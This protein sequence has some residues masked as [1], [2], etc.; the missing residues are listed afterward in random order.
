MNSFVGSSAGEN[1]QYWPVKNESGEEI[2]A[3][4]CMRITGTFIPFTTNDGSLVQPGVANYGFTVAKP[5]E[6]GAQF[7]HM[8]NGPMTIPIGQIGQGVFGKVMQGLVHASFSVGARCGPIN[9]SWTLQGGSGGFRVVESP[10]LRASGGTYAGIVQTVIQ[11]PLLFAYGTSANAG[12]TQCNA[13]M[14]STASSFLI[15]TTALST[16]IALG[17]TVSLHWLDGRW[18]AIKP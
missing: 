18:Y 16:G 3:Y 8:F 2:P 12:G 11:E 13:L 7:S 15:D 6:W 14:R 9:G 10:F 4:A 17:D 1:Q 5:N